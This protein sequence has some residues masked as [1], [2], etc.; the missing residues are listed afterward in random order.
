MICIW[1]LD[2]IH[3]KRTFFDSKHHVT[4]MMSL[5]CT[6]V[7]RQMHVLEKNI[8]K[9]Q[10]WASHLGDAFHSSLKG[11][12]SLV[13]WCGEALLVNW[14]KEKKKLSKFV[15]GKSMTSFQRRDIEQGRANWEGAKT[16]KGQNWAWLAIVSSEA[17][18]GFPKWRETVVCFCV[19]LVFTLLPPRCV[20]GVSVF[21]SEVH[22]GGSVSAVWSRLT[23]RSLC[24]FV[25]LTGAEVM[26]RFRWSQNVIMPQWTKG[27]SNAKQLDVFDF[28]S[29]HIDRGINSSL[30][31]SL[32]L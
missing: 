15:A 18:R 11:K 16:A 13:V 14:E 4:L 29:R 24:V 7:N 26:L 31:L 20:P 27:E 9:S 32:Y 8:H 5:T 30:P 6:L 22:C 12:T 10:Q 28:D 2:I 17:R 25:S 19:S 23:R 1:C 3:S 21:V